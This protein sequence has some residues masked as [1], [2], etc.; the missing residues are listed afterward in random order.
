MI[1]LYE[2]M[3]LSPINRCS[4]AAEV[5]CLCRSTHIDSLFARSTLSLPRSSTARALADVLHCSDPYLLPFCGRPV[6]DCDVSDIRSLL[7][8]TDADEQDDVAR[9]SSIQRNRSASVIDADLSSFELPRPR[10][11]QLLY[12]MYLL[13]LYVMCIRSLFI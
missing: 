8:A 12:G 13:L 1:G 3:F 7:A 2:T 9:S 10:R 5:N 6:F 4:P 11:V